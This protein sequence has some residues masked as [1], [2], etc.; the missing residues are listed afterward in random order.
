M[1]VVQNVPVTMLSAAQLKDFTEPFV[2]DPKVH[3]LLPP[4]T[5]MRSVI[6]RMKNLSDDLYIE[7]NMDG[8]LTLSAETDMAFM[9]TKYISLGHPQIGKL[10]NN[11]HFYGM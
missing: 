1:T 3:I 10:H 6:E 4:L 8:A 9:R 2:P 5:K 7:A 11:L